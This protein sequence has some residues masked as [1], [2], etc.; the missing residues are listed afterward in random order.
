MQRSRNK[1]VREKVK[2]ISDNVLFTHY[3]LNRHLK[4]PV[5]WLMFSCDYPSRPSPICNLNHFGFL[6]EDLLSASYPT[7]NHNMQAF[8]TT[9]VI[10][11]TDQT[12]VSHENPGWAH[13]EQ[14]K[15]PPLC[16]A[17]QSRTGTAWLKCRGS[18]LYLLGRLARNLDYICLIINL[19]IHYHDLTL[20]P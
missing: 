11:P 16:I 8:Q 4:A 6:E 2:P 7:R 19:P 20:E 15:I 12:R 3:D 9:A 18:D 1:T 10:A 17:P 13:P 14:P 5:V